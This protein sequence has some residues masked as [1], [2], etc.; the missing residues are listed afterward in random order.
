MTTSDCLEK[1]DREEE[2][3]EEEEEE[4]KLHVHLTSQVCAKQSEKNH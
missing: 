4:D 3:E 2:E 1:K